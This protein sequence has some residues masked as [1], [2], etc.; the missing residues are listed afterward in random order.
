MMLDQEL[1]VAEDLDIGA[2]GAGTTVSTNA[3]DLGAATRVG[4]GA[5]IQPYCF[6]TE[7]F[8]AATLSVE[9][10]A[11]S[12]AALTS[13]VEILSK[14]DTY[15]QAELALNMKVPVPKPAAVPNGRQY[16]GM[17][18]VAGGTVNAGK[19]TAGFACDEETAPGTLPN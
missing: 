18:F 19:V 1:V 13:D 15:V 10:V 14:S 11:A 4:A 2:A 8:S 5:K 17:R 6:V 16:L 3:I 9:V 12:N 7:A